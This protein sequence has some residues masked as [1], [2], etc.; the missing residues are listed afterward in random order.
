MRWRAV[1]LLAAAGWGCAGPTG[2]PQVDELDAG[3]LS[4]ILADSASANGVIGSQGAARIPGYPPW[5]GVT[6]MNGLTDSMRADL[7]IGTGSISKM[8]A[9]LAALRLVDRGVLHDDHSLGK[10]FPNVPNVDPAIKLERVMH[11]TSGLADY[12]AHPN[13]SATVFADLQRNWQPAELL[14]FI[15]PPLFAPGAAWNAS[16]TN[17]LLLGIIVER[18][19]GQ[20][21][22]TVFRLTRRFHVLFH[23]LLS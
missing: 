2:A 10:W 5:S 6:G 1:V 7:M 17:R 4:S 21:L 13:Y 16:N 3:R 15:G 11:N 18:E 12:G 19:T 8:Y 20:S 22:G 9:T 23:D 14:V